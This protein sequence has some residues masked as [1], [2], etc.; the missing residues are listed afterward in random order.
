MFGRDC[1]ERVT[2][3][4]AGVEKAFLRV[5]AEHGT[6]KG[7]GAEYFSIRWGRTVSNVHIMIEHQAYSVTGGSSRQGL[8]YPH[9]FLNPLRSNQGAQHM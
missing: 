9:A 6:E 8:S 3:R 4:E 7:T 2:K 1:L 5:T